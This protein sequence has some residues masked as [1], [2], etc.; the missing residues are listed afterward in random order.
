MWIYPLDSNEP[1][2]VLTSQIM[3]ASWAPDGTKLVFA[4][5]PPYFELWTADL[6]PALSTVKALGP[7]QTLDEHWQDMLRLY[8][9]RIETD[10]QDAYAY[11]DRAR[12]YDYLHERAKAEADMRRWSAVVSGRSPSDSWFGTSRGLGVSSTCPSIVNSSF[13]QKDLSMR[14]QYC[15][16]PSGRKEGVR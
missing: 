4:L 13:L 1:D 15:L 3:A 6:D 2:K 10:P 12:Y 16:L 9:R 14:F 8:T 7:G 5:G 11:S